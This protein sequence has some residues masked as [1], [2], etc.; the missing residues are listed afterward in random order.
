MGILHMTNAVSFLN[1][2]CK[3]IHGNICM[4]AVVV[5][6]TLDWKLHGFDLLSEHSLPPDQCLM[7]ASWMVGNQYKPAELGKA[8]WDTISQAPP[9]AVDAWGLGCLIQEAFSQQYMSSL[10]N[11]RRTDSIPPAL[12]G[13]YQKLLSSAPTRRL[14]PAKVAECKFLNNRLVDVVA[15]ME[16]ISV[17][18]SMDKESFFK[19]LGAALPSIP[20]AVAVQKILPLLAHA[21]EF[22]GAP[23]HAV[24]PLLLIGNTLE[25]EEFN[26]RVVPTLSKLFASPDRSLRRS[27]LESIDSYASHLTTPV[28]EEQIYVHMQSGFTDGNAYIRELTLKSMLSLAPKLTNKTLVNNVLKHLSKL[29]VD[30]EASIRANTTV[31]L[32]NIAKYLGE[33]TCKRD[34]FPPAK[35]AGLRAMVATSQYH[36]PEDAAL[37]ILPAVAPLAIE[38]MAEVRAAALQVLEVFT[39]VLKEHDAK[40]AADPVD[41]H[42]GGMGTAQGAAG[43][44]GGAPAL[45]AGSA[46][47]TWAV[48]SLMTTTG[49]AAK[50]AVASGTGP[51]AATM[52]PPTAPSIQPAAPSSTRG[53][54]SQVLPHVLPSAATAAR[55]GSSA[56][57]AGASGGPD[58]WGDGKEDDE[59]WQGLGASAAA[60]PAAPAA[61]ARTGPAAR[62]SGA[63]KPKAAGGMKLGAK[64]LGQQKLG[65]TKGLGS[66]GAAFFDEDT[67][68]W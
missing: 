1:N 17:K 67:D 45:T 59:P 46:M 56:P 68:A 6:E 8:E 47:L 13:D 25:S 63:A 54:V 60:A 51:P 33:S 32:G 14:N 44:G 22:G 48:S 4:D 10:D 43:A 18:D 23:P 5:T 64:P 42:I 7:H 37:R 30:E 2:D 9:W 61:R 24:A 3:L 49:L 19:K 34:V 36:G 21:L 62:A 41:S 52:A 55:K 20:P 29:Q 58:G 28:L 26:R 12:L 57:A 35:I 66:T 27:L 53:P 11:L 39:Q 31:L 16:N 65:V 50:P 38:P 15:F 40:R